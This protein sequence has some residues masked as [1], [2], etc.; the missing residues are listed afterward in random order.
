MPA[1]SLLL[2]WLL[3]PTAFGLKSIPALKE[4]T[5][6]CI[7]PLTYGFLLCQLVLLAQNE[8][9]E[10]LL[11]PPYPQLGG[12]ATQQFSSPG[13]TRSASATNYRPPPCF[14]PPLA[15]KWLTDFFPPLNL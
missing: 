13:S 11:H 4:A 14:S 12:K 5:F 9:T 1:G 10:L 15:L 3:G 6:T 8:G 7:L 2:L